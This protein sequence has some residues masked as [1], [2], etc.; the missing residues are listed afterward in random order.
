[1]KLAFDTRTS[2]VWLMSL[3]ISILGC[4]ESDR[5]SGTVF[6]D[7][8]GVVI[9]D[10]PGMAR[11]DSR[12]RVSAEPALEI[13]VVDGDSG[14]QLF[15]VRQVS[16]L[17]DGRIVVANAGT[18]QLRFFDGRTG[19]H[20]MSVGGP[21]DG[22]GEFRSLWRFSRLRGDSIVAM[23]ADRLSWFTPDGTFLRQTRI[24]SQEYFEPK[25]SPVPAFVLADASLLMFVYE[26]EDPGTTHP[27]AVLRPPLGFA[28]LSVTENRIYRLGTFPGHEQFFYKVAGETR[29]GGMMPF[30]RDT[31][32][33][34]S[35]RHFYVGDNDAYEIRVYDFNGALE[36]IVRKRHIHLVIESEDVE[37][38]KSERLALV[39]D[40]RRQAELR[41]LA[42]AP[43]PETWPAFADLRADEDGNLWVEEF[44]RS[45]DEQPRWTVFNS[46]GRILGVVSTP[47]G[48]RIDEIGTN[49]LLGVWEDEDEV[50]YVR[51]FELVKP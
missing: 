16:R 4:N 2:M 7:S 34:F 43:F 51:L 12:W 23:S 39:V 37:R 5:D 25:Y 3:S 36:R 29:L 33:A 14:Y 44:R 35:R 31:K 47:I 11:P 41:R 6:S 50:E 45:G 24:M 46:D 20:L 19:R 40:E 49:Y 9:A 30:L 1:M 28:R 8:S 26:R 10:N 22:P 13:G 27:E 42:A 32:I 21:G 48:L 18:E 38:Y 17:R 15:N